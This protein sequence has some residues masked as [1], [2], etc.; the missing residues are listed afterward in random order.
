MVRWLALSLGIISPGESRLAA[1]SVFDAMLHFQFG[2]RRDATI[3]ELMGYI[4]ESWGGINEK[5]LRY[6]LLQLKKMNIAENSKGRYSLA[7]PG[8]GDRHDP[9]NWVHSYIDSQV[10]PIKEKM[11]LATKELRTRQ[12]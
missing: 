6:H 12:A 4:E 9:E 7:S 5:T 2:E 11:G 3:P 8:I 1:V 10:R